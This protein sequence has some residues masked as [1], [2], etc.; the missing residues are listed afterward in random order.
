MKY[1]LFL[2]CRIPTFVPAYESA[3][4]AV[5]AALDVRLVDLPFACCGQPIRNRDRDAFVY[6]AARNLA[7]AEREGLDIL[8]PCKCC[9]G[10]LR[11]AAR[12]LEED[13]SL[14][15]RVAAALAEE[16]LAW[17]GRCEVEHLLPVLARKV[18]SARLR[19]AITSPRAGLRVAASYG[20]HALRPAGVTHFDNPLAPTIFESLVAVT[21][22]TPIEWA[23]RLECCGDPLHE[24]NGPL[25]DRLTRAKLEDA[26]RCGADVVC[27]ACPHCHE[28]YS[29]TM[30]AGQGPNLPLMLYPQLLG[31]AMGIQAGKLGM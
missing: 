11:H 4:R 19:A 7:L 3:T 14:R 1:A 25:S 12:F 6:S 22:A 21:G 26:Q 30:A 29:A 31:L 9:F 18:D 20:C 13:A 8:A 10:S 2:G 5:L 16:G 24:A 28:R 17:T 27:T 23:R 15:E